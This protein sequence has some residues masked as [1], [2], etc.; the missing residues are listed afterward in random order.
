MQLKYYFSWVHC[1]P[2]GT[3]HPR[4]FAQRV[5]EQSKLPQHRPP[6]RLPGPGSFHKDASAPA[7]TCFRCRSGCERATGGQSPPGAESGFVHRERCRIWVSGERA[8]FSR[9]RVSEQGSGLQTGKEGRG[10]TRHP[11]PGL[12][13]GTG[14]ALEAVGGD[15]APPGRSPPCLLAERQGHKPPL[16]T[17]Y[18]S[19]TPTPGRAPRLGLDGVTGSSGGK[20]GGGRRAGA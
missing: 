14:L 18:G 4:P 11:A 9:S 8:L 2:R 6:P 3:D 10:E 17:H 1:T 16:P 7:L 19:Q 5:E 12:G 13:A 15:H 20:A